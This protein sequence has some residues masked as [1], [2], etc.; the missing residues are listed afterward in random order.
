M[1]LLLRSDY[2]GAVPPKEYDEIITQLR[3]WCSDRGRQSELAKHLGVSRKAVSTW[4]LKTRR[5]NIDSFFK[6]KA[7]LKKKRREGQ[8]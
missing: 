6:L 2:T 7:F 3:L 8:K 5:P 1:T 4:I